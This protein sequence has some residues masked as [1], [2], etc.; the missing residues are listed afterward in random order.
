MRSLVALLLAVPVLAQEEDPID[1]TAAGVVVGVRGEP[2]SGVRVEAW[3]ALEPARFLCE[4]ASGA[5]GRFLLA[6]RRS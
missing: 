3:D 2:I 4:G 6:L 5:D 1:L